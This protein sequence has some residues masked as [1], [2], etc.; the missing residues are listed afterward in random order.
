MHNKYISTYDTEIYKRLT[1][2][3]FY[4]RINCG[5]SLQSYLLLKT[6]RYRGSKSQDKLAKPI[7]HKKVIRNAFNNIP[8]KFIFIRQCISFEN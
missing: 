7:L 4:I 6:A 2:F 1:P 8:S 5:Y 3:A